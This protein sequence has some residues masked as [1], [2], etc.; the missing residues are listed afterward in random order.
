MKNRTNAFVGT[1]AAAAMAVSAVSPAMANDRYENKQHND[2]ISAGEVIAGVAIL[3]GIAAILASD[4][5]DNRR[6]DT[7]YD[8]G[9]D[10]HDGH[11]DH[12]GHNGHSGHDRGYQGGYQSGYQGGYQDGYRNPARLATKLCINSVE[13][14]NRYNTKKVTDIRDIDRTR[15]GYR[16]EGR[17]IVP[18][19]GYRNY[20]YN[21]G[22]NEYDSGRFTCYVEHGRVVDIDYNGIRGY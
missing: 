1:A 14:G 2:K 7:R 9:H 15:Y 19:R 6:H 12:G 20:G 4:K 18:G 17:L 8:G 5:H 13:Y 22:Y 16:V 21:R 11:N 10:G 3:G